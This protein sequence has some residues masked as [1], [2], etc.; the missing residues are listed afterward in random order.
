MLAKINKLLIVGVLCL[1]PTMG[2][3]SDQRQEPIWTSEM[4][5]S[6]TY[7]LPQPVYNVS[8]T[9][10][11]RTLPAAVEWTCPMHPR[12]RQSVPGK[13]SMCGM[14]LVR[15]DYRSSANNSASGS[16]NSHSSHSSG[17]GHSGSSGCGSCGG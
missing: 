14:D 10:P 11:S 6:P 16:R 9:T 15:S 13:C 5:S 4:A 12:F 17:S 3:K 7:A 1:A 2:C 8:Q